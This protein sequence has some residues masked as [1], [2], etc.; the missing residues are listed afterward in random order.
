M[1][2]APW[3]I[4]AEIDKPYY[5]KRF[6]NQ[7]ITAKCFATNQPDLDELK[8]LKQITIFLA[9]KLSVTPLTGAKTTSKKIRKRNKNYKNS[10]ESINKTDMKTES[11]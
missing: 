8:L 2:F 7:Q 5:T 3:T 6:R 9:E 1:D 11:N 4:S 10:S